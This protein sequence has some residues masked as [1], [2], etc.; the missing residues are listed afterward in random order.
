MEIDLK[1]N[2]KCKYLISHISNLLMT[3]HDISQAGGIWRM[4]VTQNQIVINRFHNENQYRRVP[5]R[6]M[7][8]HTSFCQKLIVLLGTCVWSLDTYFNLSPLNHLCVLFVEILYQARFCLQISYPAILFTMQMGLLNPG[9]FIIHA[10]LPGNK[11]SVH[12]V[13]FPA[14]RMHSHPSAGHT[15]I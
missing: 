10:L 15:T 4:C 9:S 6:T 3:M 1:L 2:L 7:W 5:G 12:I 14:G 11:Q 13:S 8:T